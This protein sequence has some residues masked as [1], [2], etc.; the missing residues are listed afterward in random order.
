VKF[1]DMDGKVLRQRFVEDGK[2]AVAPQAPKL[3]GYEFKG[4]DKSFSNITGA[5][6]VTAEYTEI[7][8]LDPGDKPKHGSGGCS[9]GF[10]AL[11]MLGTAAFILKR[12]K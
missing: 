11:A 6:A 12:S 3:E 5:L 8:E 4:W 10:L 2:A 7:E 1:V 9:A